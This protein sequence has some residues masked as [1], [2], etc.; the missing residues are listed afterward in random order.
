MTGRTRK[1]TRLTVSLDEADYGA[2]NEI[3][4]Q[5]DVS[6]SWIIRQA[7]RQFIEGNKNIEVRKGGKR[8]VG[9][10]S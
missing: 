3:A 9:P 5:K 4:S 7:I 6:L 2:L 1:S 10:S 8:N